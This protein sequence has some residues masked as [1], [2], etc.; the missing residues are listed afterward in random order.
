MNRLS[1]NF[2]F[3]KKKQPKI[4]KEHSKQKNSQ[5]NSDRAISSRRKLSNNN[6]NLLEKTETLAN[7]SNKKSKNSSYLNCVIQ[8]VI[9][10]MFLNHSH[11]FKSENSLN[12]PINPINEANTSKVLYQKFENLRNT[13]TSL[14][15]S[16]LSWRSLS[17]TSTPTFSYQILRPLLVINLWD[18]SFSLLLNLCT[19]SLAYSTPYLTKLFVGAIIYRG[20]VSFLAIFVILISI[21]CFFLASIFKENSEF[22]RKRAK[23]RSSVILRQ[24]FYEKIKAA[25]YRFLLDAEP[26]FVSHLIFHETERIVQFVGALP[27][28]ISAPF[29]FLQMYIGLFMIIGYRAWLPS[30]IY[31][32]LLALTVLMKVNNV[33]RKNRYSHMNSKR[34]L[35]LDELIPNI[36]RTKLYSMESSFEKLLI[37]IRIN[38]LSALKIIHLFDSLIEFISIMVPISCSAASVVYYNISSGKVL[39]V[40]GTYAVVSILVVTAVSFAQVSTAFEQY[41]YHKD[42][43]TA[44]KLVLEKIIEKGD[45]KKTEDEINLEKSSPLS[46]FRRSVQRV[47]HRFTMRAFESELTYLSPFGDMTPQ[48]RKLPS[49]G[50]I[51][52]PINQKRKAINNFQRLSDLGKSKKFKSS[53]SLYQN[54]QSGGEL[55]VSISNADFYVDFTTSKQ[56]L[57]TFFSKHFIS[58]SQ[59]E[60]QLT[61]LFQ[62]LEM[63][64]I[65]RSFK[66]SK[67]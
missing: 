44:F 10:S 50:T 20:G 65:A 61:E 56:I 29:S 36:Y 30:T 23:S 58:D 3:K 11:L 60:E 22:L 43:I 48:K 7:D 31:L 62:H 17:D 21:T 35:V 9:K 25:N 47:N 26:N 46:K 37:K 6:E 4:N 39:S 14:I 28:C 63:N 2:K 16:I 42:S 59:E 13:K 51:K 57:K 8:F 5:L 33:K 64:T 1:R 15:G 38:E 32:M 40:E 67:S 49:I 24:I 45:E 18:L 55:A 41:E 53:L 12:I 34:T 54:N 66:Y 19:E 52:A 27:I